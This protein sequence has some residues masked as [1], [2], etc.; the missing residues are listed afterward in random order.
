MTCATHAITVGRGGAL[1]GN[2]S[3][4]GDKSITHRALILSALAEGVSQIEGALDARDTRATADALVTLGAEI[5]WPLGGGI[6]VQGTGGRW[7]VPTAPLDFGNSGTGLRLVA[8]AIAGRG[9]SATLDGD[10]SLRRRPMAR[11]ADPLRAMGA[12]IETRDGCP[13]LVI[14]GKGRL[15][16]LDY[17]LP[18]ASAQ[19]K[20]A[21]LLAGLAASDNTR[22]ED[23]WRTRDHTER[24]LPRFGAKLRVADGAITLRPGPLTA[25]EVHV[26]GDPSSA[27]FLIAAAL[28]S[29]GSNLM[30]PGLCV[31]PTRTGFLE[32]LSRMGAHIERHHVRD[33]CGEP[34]ADLR[35]RFGALSGTRVNADEIP[36]AIDELPVLMVLAATAAGE[37]VIR[38]AGE[39]RRKESDRI[40]TM[41]AGLE[42]LGARMK[43]AGDRITLAGG[44]FTRGG[45]LAAAGD[46]R[47]AMALAL[48]GFAAPEAVTVGGAEW[49]ETSF[50]DFAD[51]LR[52]AGAGLRRA[53]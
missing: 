29:P 20:S 47:V 11:I 22:I 40:E 6:Q 48:A 14:G 41:R 44:G 25:T 39:L 32:V 52:A 16:G 1:T 35:V 51:T 26:P 23:P 46:H 9:I 15:H 49:I 45:R 24:M 17:R 19:V 21:L 38:G 50:P 31:N 5:E 27:A 36:A 37:T 2:L 18:V 42:A 43:V 34:V 30:L 12:A 13:P 8:G 10:A 33:L 3:I 53:S 7:R 4:P 28:L